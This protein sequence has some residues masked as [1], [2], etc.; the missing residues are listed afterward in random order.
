VCVTFTLNKYD[1]ESCTDAL[2][3]LLISICG[4]FDSEYLA[5]TTF[6]EADNLFGSLISAMCVASG[7]TLHCPLSD[8]SPHIGYWSKASMG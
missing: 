7:K 1:S 6:V 4:G 2:Y 8:D 5:S 3:F